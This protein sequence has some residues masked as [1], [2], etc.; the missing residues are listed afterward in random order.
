[1]CNRTRI[2]NKWFD[3][4]EVQR[5]ARECAEFTFGDWP[6]DE[7]IGTSDISIATR[8]A[9]SQL[10]FTQAESVGDDAVV[11]PAEFFAV[12][13]AITAHMREILN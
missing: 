4:E 12:R 8:A 10:G 5:V 7:G 9:L 3:R 13:Q 11:T 1:M 6:E 2:G